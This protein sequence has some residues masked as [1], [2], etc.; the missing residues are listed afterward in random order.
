VC[1]GGD[2]I[3]S[4]TRQV[5][6]I[7]L[8]LFFQKKESRPK[9]KIVLN[10][11]LY[12]LETTFYRTAL[13][14]SCLYGIEMENADCWQTKATNCRNKILKARC[15]RRLVGSKSQRKYLEIIR[16]TKYQWKMSEIGKP[17]LNT[18]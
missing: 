17:D 18:Y 1:G 15:R 2:N 12:N 6:L 10:V 7:R 13:V 14:S 3:Q 9:C 4:H 11:L 16:Y 8:L 5:D